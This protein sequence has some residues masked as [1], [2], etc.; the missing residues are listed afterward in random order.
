MNK[1]KNKH[2]ISVQ[3]L[4]SFTSVHVLV[5]LPLKSNAEEAEKINVVY[6]MNLF[7]RDDVAGI[8]FR[9]W[10]ERG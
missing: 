6:T 1:R 4:F 2:E 3:H 5:T 8:P 10:R 9:N 7:R